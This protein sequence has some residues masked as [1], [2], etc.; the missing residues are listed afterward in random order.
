M[1]TP[2]KPTR[3]RYQVLFL[4]FVNVVI[5]Y[6]DRSNLA[7]A[8]SD[9][10]NEFQFTSVQMGLIFSAFSWTY[11]AFQIPGGIFVK[12]FSPRILYAVSLI[13]WSLATVAQGFA[14]GFATLFGLRMATGTFEAP[15]FP[16]N[17]RVVSSWFPDNERASAIAIYTSGQFLGLAFL[18]PVLSSIQVQVGW[19][20]LFVV[21]GLVGIV[22]G[23]VW[24]FF[25]RDPLKH[26]RANEAELEHIRKG[27]GI[28]EQKTETKAGTKKFKW[29]D[30][31]EVL[32]H[33][34]LWGIYIGQ[35]AV[36]SALWFF[37]TWFP[38]YLVDYRG[39]EFIKSGY[40]ASV[41]YLAAFCGVLCSGFLSDYLVK[42]GISVA[43]ARKRPI[44]IGLLVST[45][46]IGANY[47]NTPALIILCMSIS[48]FGVGFAS[49]TWI[50]VSTLA[51]RHLID[52]TG[53][54]FNFIGQLSGIIVPS[55]IGYM[56]SDGNF[57][58]A[59]VFIALLGLAGACSY[60]FLVGSVE[61]VKTHDELLTTGNG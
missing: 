46:I 51:P 50:F 21:T 61:R 48:F 26:T 52:V 47:V 14:R 2:L 44:I 60:L 36:N 15:A 8:A 30:L 49:I 31:A 35:F 27:G 6:M 42:R 28:L 12:R 45:A 33:R 23:L 7:V 37:L 19:R 24:Y 17:N 3:V 58:P 54:V 56:V 11:L 57:A 25:Y 41:P 5:N 29:S 55:V 43:K 40:W 1:V 22:W 20:G 53:G 32:S 59:L 16:I 39:M 18:M 38:K 13:T 10:S 34:K 4:V 9:I